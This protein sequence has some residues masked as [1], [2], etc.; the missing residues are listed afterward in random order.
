MDGNDKILVTYVS[1]YGTTGEV[2]EVIAEV[3]RAQGREVVLRP[4][5]DVSDVRPYRGVIL[6]APIY[7]GKLLEGAEDFMQT[8][9]E[10]LSLQPVAYFTVG[11]SMRD[12]SPESLVEAR[13]ALAPLREAI[14]PVDEAHFAGSAS[15]LPFFMRLFLRFRGSGGDYRDVQTIRA[16][17]VRLGPRL[18]SARMTRRF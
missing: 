17:A 4:V 8:F 5:A 11:L 3:L 12:K 1:R 18:V 14:T 10:E 9:R 16:W 2:A 15:R 6:G 13:Q 7:G